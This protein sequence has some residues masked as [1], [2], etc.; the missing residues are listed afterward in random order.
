MSRKRGNITFYFHIEKE[1]HNE[2]TDKKL[3][4]SGYVM[5]ER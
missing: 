3:K 5:A 4:E 1:M 2:A